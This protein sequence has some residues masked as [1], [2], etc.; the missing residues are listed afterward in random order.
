[1]LAPCQQSIERRTKGL[2]PFGEVIFDL[3]RNR[4]VHDSRDDAVPLQLTKL[5][6]QH[7]LRDARDRALQIREAKGLAAEEMKED[8]ELPAALQHS[9]R[10][11]N[12][13]GRRRCRMRMVTH[14]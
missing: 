10:V 9:D 8:H 12:S 3:R 7:L 14:R 4:R 2:S 1:M 11:L 6:R 5:L 13:G